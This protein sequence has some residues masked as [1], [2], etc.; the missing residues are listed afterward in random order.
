VHSEK[1]DLPWGHQQDGL[2]KSLASWLTNPFLS[3]L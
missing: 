3:V 1:W 2:H